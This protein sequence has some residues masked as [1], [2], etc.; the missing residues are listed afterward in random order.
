MESV[1]TAPFGGEIVPVRDRYRDGVQLLDR[2]TRWRRV[3]KLPETAWFDAPTATEE[4]ERRASRP[5]DVG[6]LESW[7][8]N[9]Y[10][11]VD[12]LVPEPLIDEMLAAVDDLFSDDS[13]G[14]DTALP[15]LEFCDLQFVP[16][17]RTTVSHASLLAR[18]VDERLAARD[19][20][21]WRVHAMIADSPAARAVSGYPEVERVAS[22]ILGI[23]STAAYSINFHN[24]SLQALHEDSAV[25]H[26]GVPNLIVGAWIACEDITE[27]S[28][29]LV[30]YPKSHTRAMY[31]GFDDDYPNLN[32][33]TASAELADRYNRDVA[34]TAGDFEEHRF[35]AK[36]GDVLFWHGMLIHG[37]SP[38]LDPS[39]T[40]RSFVVHFVPDGADHVG[41]VTRTPRY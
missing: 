1:P 16:G 28:G 36:K 11:I 2:V 6:I 37:G 30:Y 41:R 25:F 13:F 23:P 4:I 17:E 15:A 39:A 8:N 35:L 5:G 24:G 26:L 18:P 14:E 38:I 29:P 7:V 27:A 22:M 20:S 34:A 33:R 3:A 31:A 19:R 12:G 32:H 21:Q 10:A 40:R 9:G